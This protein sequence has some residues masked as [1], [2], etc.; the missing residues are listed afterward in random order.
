[1][2]ETSTAASAP[3]PATRIRG[4]E[5]DDVWVSVIPPDVARRR[6]IRRRRRSRRRA[7]RPPPPPSLTGTSR[8]GSDDGLPPAAV[9]EDVH[10]PATRIPGFDGEDIW[11]TVIP[12][13]IAR[14]MHRRRRRRSRR[15][16][17]RPPAPSPPSRAPSLTGTSSADSDDDAPPPTA[18]AAA[19]AAEPTSVPLPSS[20]TFRPTSNPPS[21]T[22]PTLPIPPPPTT[23]SPTTLSGPNRQEYSSTWK[24]Y[25]NVPDLPHLTTT[26]QSPHPGCGEACCFGPGMS[27]RH[28]R[29]RKVMFKTPEGVLREVVI[30]V[31]RSEGEGE[32]GVSES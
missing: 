29:L 19:T 1:M 20:P 11:V 6:H 28:T 25:L 16:A 17:A 14:R 24:K 5:G 2:T 10:I 18:V 3:I 32:V 21:P 27:G 12:E 8:A 23:P 7:A 9:T 26:P 15:R 4:H 22:T 31:P 30:E 13:E